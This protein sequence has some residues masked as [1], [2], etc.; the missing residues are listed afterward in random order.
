MEYIY[1]R[2]CMGTESEKHEFRVIYINAEKELH[3]FL[4]CAD[5]M[6]E[7]DCCCEGATVYFGI[8]TRGVKTWELARVGPTR[9]TAAASKKTFLGRFWLWSYRL[10][11]TISVPLI[12]KKRQ[13]KTKQISCLCKCLSPETTSQRPTCGPN[14]KNLKSLSLSLSPLAESLA[15]PKAGCHYLDQT[16]QAHTS[17]LM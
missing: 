14:Q 11:Q 3:Y 13:K 10:R 2:T 15:N 12:K 9:C 8:K 5:E 16:S 1:T 4:V 6:F 7:G 17:L